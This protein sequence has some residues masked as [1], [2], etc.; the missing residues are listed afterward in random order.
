MGS[1]GNKF[2]QEGRLNRTKG[3]IEATVS[4]LLSLHW[5]PT[6]LDYW[7]TTIGQPAEW[8]N[9]NGE[10][11]TRF[12]I[13]ARAIHD[14]QVLRWKSVSEHAYGAGLETGIPSFVSAKRAISSVRRNQ[15]HK[16]AQAFETML[17]GT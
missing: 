10:G 7:I 2:L 8:V 6:A 16:A 15:Q 14:A 12:Q 9:L 5:K 1:G 11:F 3:P 13:T 4:A 17:V